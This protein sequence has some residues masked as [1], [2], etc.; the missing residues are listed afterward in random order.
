MIIAK[1]K[2]YFDF[3]EKATRLEF[4]IGIV[5]VPM[6]GVMLVALFLHLLFNSGWI[7]GFTAKFVIGFMLVVLFVLNLWLVLATAVRRCRGLCISPDYIFLFLVPFTSSLTFLV[8]GFAKFDAS[9]TTDNTKSQQRKRVLIW[10]I[11]ALIVVVLFWAAS[12]L[13][14]YFFDISVS[15]N[16]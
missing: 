4:W 14:K 5:L 3:Q 15:I 6:A 2:K 8:F 1:I 9:E 16:F 11:K 10:H 7:L 13:M 12:F